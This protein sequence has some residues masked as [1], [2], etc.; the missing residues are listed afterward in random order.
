MGLQF[1]E[2]VFI[3][4]LLCVGH[5][6]RYWGYSCDENPLNIMPSQCVCVCV[7]V[8]VCAHT[9]GRAGVRR[10]TAREVFSLSFAAQPAA[11]RLSD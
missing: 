9:R 6:S 7:C 10:Q 8:R 4:S 11:L 1:I 2:Q 5:C 3:G